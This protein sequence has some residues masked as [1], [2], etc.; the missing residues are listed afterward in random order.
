MRFLYRTEL[1]DHDPIY[2]F[3]W[4]ERTGALERLTPPWTQLKVLDRS[5]GI[6]AGG[7]VTLRVRNGL[8][9]STWKLRHS[10]Y[11]RGTHFRE[12]QV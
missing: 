5:G 1:P 3:D 4:H 8:T 6:R 9:S 12:E 11:Q 2:V 10:D 7:R